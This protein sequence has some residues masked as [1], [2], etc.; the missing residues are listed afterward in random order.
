MEFMYIGGRIWRTSTHSSLRERNQTRPRSTSRHRLCRS[1]SVPNPLNVD[2][3]TGT[4]QEGENR[5]M[6]AGRSKVARSRD[7]FNPLLA[8]ASGGAVHV[9]GVDNQR[10]PADMPLFQDPGALHGVVVRRA[11][12]IFYDE[13]A[14]AHAV[15]VEQCAHDVGDGRPWRVGVH[16]AA[17]H[18]DRT[19]RSLSVQLDGVQTAGKRVLIQ[20]GLKSRSAR[21]IEP[22][23]KHDD[24]LRLGRTFRNWRGLALQRQQRQVSHRGH[25]ED[26]QDDEAE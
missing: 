18:H 22:G 7:Y 15:L 17:A 20:L 16:F 21:R 5:K 10:H 1:H 23:R 12:F 13:V 9:H 3:R 2:C 4:R 24:G 8:E 26:R 14:C 6:K 19:G 25:A 11:R